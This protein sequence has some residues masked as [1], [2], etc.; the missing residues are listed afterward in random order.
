MKRQQR[1]KAKKMNDSVFDAHMRDADQALIDTFGVP[2]DLIISPGAVAQTIHVDI[3]KDLSIQTL[4]DRN[5]VASTQ[6]STGMILATLY[7]NQVPQ[8]LKSARLVMQG[9]RYLFTEPRV[10]GDLVEFILLAE[11]DDAKSGD[12]N[13]QFL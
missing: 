12:R 9:K 5:R 1:L 2:L 13:T 7:N 4:G 6:R 10:S 8:N 3:E 11:V